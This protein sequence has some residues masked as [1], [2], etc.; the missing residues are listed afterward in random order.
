MPDARKEEPIAGTEQGGGF[1][2]EM[3]FDRTNGP[4]V[5]KRPMDWRLTGPNSPFLCLH[6]SERG[7]VSRTE[8]AAAAEL[9]TLQKKKVNCES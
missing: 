2:G 9:R 8:A 1:S 3:L 5:A 6:T 4:K 7:P